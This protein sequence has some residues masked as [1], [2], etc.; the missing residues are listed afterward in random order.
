MWAEEV[1]VIDF[2]QHLQVLFLKFDKANFPECWI[3]LKE[4]NYWFFILLFSNEE[5]YQ[6]LKG[7]SVIKLS[8]FS[9]WVNYTS[10]Y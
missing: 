2:D 5:K 1:Y 10:N 9:I 7:M 8:L 6:K 4:K 3:E